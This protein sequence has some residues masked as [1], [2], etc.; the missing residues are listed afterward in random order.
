MTPYS[1]FKTLQ[2]MIHKRQI[3]ALPQGWNRWRGRHDG[4]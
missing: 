3:N 2:V 4:A 1:P